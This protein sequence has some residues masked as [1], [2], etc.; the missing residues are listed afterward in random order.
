MQ[1]RLKIFKLKIKEIKNS[2]ED[3]DQKQ[4]L[5]HLANSS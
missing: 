3:E 4:N 2:K 5:K 1:K